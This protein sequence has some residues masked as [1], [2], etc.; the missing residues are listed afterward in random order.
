MDFEWEKYKRA[1]ESEFTIINKQKKEV[2]F[3]I[4][5]VQNDILPK[6][7]VQNIILKARKLGFSSLMLGIGAIKF[8]FGQNERVV[9][10]SFDQSAA[11]RQL[12]RA[13]QFIRSFE[14]K[15]KIKL[16]LRYNSKI[17]M[18]MVA[19]D[20]ETGREYTNTLSVGTAKS[21][22][23]GRGD[24][25]TFL[26]LT[27]VAFCDDLGLLLAGVGEALVDNAM[28]TLET[29]ANGYGEFKD[30]WDD[31][32]VGKTGFKT[33]FYG[34]EWEYGKDFLEQR[35][36]KLGYLFSQEYPM[37]PQ[38]A[39]ITTAGLA[40]KPW[41]SSIH[42]IEPF[43][44]PTTWQY[45]RGVDYGSAHFTA[46]TRLATD[47][48]TFFMDCCY[49]DNKRSIKEH[50]DALLAQDYGK[51]TVIS[52]GDPSGAQWATEFGQYN[53]YIQ[54]AVKETGQQVRSWVEFCVEK[55]NEMLKPVPGH[56]V[57]L[58]D[59]RKIENAP[60]LFVFNNDS[61]Q[62]LIKQIINLKWRQSAGGDT[63][64]LLDDAGDPMGGHYDL[65]AALRYFAVSYSKPATDSELPDDTLQ[66]KRGKM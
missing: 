15:N 38:E 62:P 27:E 43:E 7:T 14:Y 58:P 21:S 22:S 56:T 10:M 36:K 47:G 24:D 31:S 51:G 52:W 32:V 35:K 25:I 46:S 34:S 2:D 53:F 16:D 48:D 40:H 29:T 20:K 1:I 12:L 61:N 30:F 44:I 55:V 18:M 49:L 8:L 66:F 39:F 50:A 37:T 11:A 26:H 59:G 9:S 42:V 28:L 5:N 54:Q 23:F 6:L 65:M 13:K 41:D 63:L 3:I 64:P 4:N 17:E 45:V 57:Y 33:F 19:T 60:H